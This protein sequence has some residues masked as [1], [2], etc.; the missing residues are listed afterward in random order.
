M[1]KLKVLYVVD[2][3]CLGGAQ[4]HVVMLARGLDKKGFEVQVCSLYD[5]E[6]ESIGRELDAA[7]INHVTLGM[8]KFVDWRRGLFGLHRV[9]KA[10]APDLIHTHLLPANVYGRLVGR[11]MSVP[12][13]TTLHNNFRGMLPTQRWRERLLLGLERCTA[14]WSVAQ[15]AVSAQ[16][17]RDYEEQFGRSG[18]EVI[19]NPVDVSVFSPRNDNGKSRR[20]WSQCLTLMT[21][22]RL[23]E[24]KGHIYLV[25]ALPKLVEQIASCRLLVIG[26]GP[27]RAPLQAE[28]EAMLLKNKV[29][30]L[31]ARSDV[32]DWLNVADVL[33]L[34]SL[35]EGLPLVLLE[36]MAAGKPI[37]ASRVGGIPEVLSD[38]KTGIL[39]APRSPDAIAKAVCRLYKNQEFAKQLG[40]AA[41][42]HAEKHFTLPRIVKQW[43]I[44][45]S[46]LAKR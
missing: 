24:E 22:G 26:D 36:A 42:L 4:R 46:Q 5:R 1:G 21:I 35:T 11:F 40:H 3:L 7:D 27:Q 19:P 9:A 13:V 12:V 6:D 16:V 10:M 14:R 20:D 43:E 8:R 2:S 39:V 29:C 25:R 17:R 33:L 23:S 32:K 18:I 38:G 45:Y 30:F 31:G 28:V 37:V 41:R 15:V 44:L 34:P